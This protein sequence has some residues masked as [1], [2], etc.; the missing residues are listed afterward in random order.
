MNR[1]HALF[2]RAGVIAAGALLGLTGVALIATPASA[3][4]SSVT[5]TAKCD[6]ATGEWVVTWNIESAS[7]PK[8]V[9]KYKLVEVVAKTYV[10]GKATAVTIPEL[11]VTDDYRHSVNDTLTATLRADRNVTKA[12]LAVRVEWDN[13][14]KERRL[15][16]ATV[17]FCGT[18]EAPKPTPTPT[19]PEPPAP[20]VPN[21]SASIQADCEGIAHV[22]LNNADDA[23]APAKFTVKGGDDFVEKVKVKPGKSTTVQVPAE[24]ATTITVAVEGSKEPLFQGTPKPADDCVKPGEPTGAFKSTCD[25]LIFEINNPE[26]GKTVTATFT[27]N[28]GEP[29]TLTV[30]PGMSG[31]VSFPAEEGLTVTPSGEGIE[32]P[33]PI[34]WEKPEDCTPGAGGGDPGLP[35]TG[36]AAGGIAAGA[37]VLL[38]IGGGLFV[39]ARRRKLRFTA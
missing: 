5:G 21:P 12:S 15:R 18:C 26:D 13:G 11:A 27:P 24:H 37:A 17:K 36:A 25:E 34:A 32:N 16:P 4:H 28:K 19:N 2:R 20:T 8:D 38:A 7:T 31:T 35:V 29:Q 9:E 14:F 23:T 10:G 3:H 33:E 6:P 30:E 1:L 22:T 39:M